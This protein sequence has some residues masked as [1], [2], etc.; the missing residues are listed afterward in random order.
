MRLFI[1][2]TVANWP[3]PKPLYAFGGLSATKDSLLAALFVPVHLAWLAYFRIAFG[4]VMTWEVWRYF[5]YN[6]ISRYWITPNFHFTY[7]GFGWVQPWPGDGMYLHFGLLGVLA[8]CIALGLWYRITTILF[9]LGFTYVFLLDQTYYLN[10]FYLISLLSFLMIF[11]PAHRAPS[12]DSALDPTLRS[13]YAPAWTLWLLRAQIGIVYFYGGIAK[14][15]SD[16]L[17]GEPMRMWLE[18]R[19]DFPVIGPYFTSEWMVYSFSYGGLLLDL[20]IVPF[21]LW[22]RTRVLAFIAGTLFHLMNAELFSIGIFPWFMICAT[23][24][25]FDPDWPIRLFTWNGPQPATEQAADQSKERN[26]P[27]RSLNRREQLTVV[28]LFVYLI[29]QLTIPLRHFLYP[30]NVNWTEEGHRFAWHMKLRDKNA[31]AQF[32]ATDPI[33]QVTWEIPLEEHLTDRQAWKMAGRPDMVLQF[34]HKMADELRQDGQEQVEIR[35]IVRASLNGRERQLLIDP[36][37][38]LSKQSDSLWPAS[39]IMP[40]EQPLVI[41]R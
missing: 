8:L 5:N 39:W 2:N 29:L 17:N 3:L 23:T 12:L 22:R 38:D 24:I 19:T 26:S 40:L 21:L 20:L 34:A 14:L 15:N 31:S 41:R 32:W 27:I 37:V 4:L 33:K 10:H 30:G 36:E 18:E 1:Q 11:L 35:A 7:Y 13:T 9:F 16:W 25:F 28:L 6:W